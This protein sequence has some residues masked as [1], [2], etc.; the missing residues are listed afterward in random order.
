[1]ADNPNV[2]VSEFIVRCERFAAATIVFQR[3]ERFGRH[4]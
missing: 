1:M 3:V 2:Q 4:C